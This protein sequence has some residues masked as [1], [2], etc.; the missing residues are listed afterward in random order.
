MKSRISIAI[1][2]TGF[3]GIAAQLLLLREL[4][5]V[6]AG[7]EFS[8]GIVL[9]NWL[10]LEAFG[11][12]FLGKKAED[13]K[14]KITAFAVLTLFFALSL[15]AMVFLT[16]ILRNILDI[17]I[18]EGVG[19]LPVL[20]SS[21]LVLLPVSFLHGALFTFGC[22]VYS[23]YS[24]NDAKTIGRAYIYET[25]G[26]MLGGL[27]WTYLLIPYFH[28]FETA[29]ALVVLN[30][31]VCCYLLAGKTHSGLIFL[32]NK[33]R[34]IKSV[35]AILSLLLLIF[36]GYYLISGR[37]DEL[38]EKSIE[39]QW[40]GQNI[41]HYQNSIYG[42]ITIMEVEGQYTFFLDG[43]PHI[44]TPI[45]D[46][47]F[48]EEFVH[49][50]LLSHPNPEKILILSG[51]A[52]GIINEILKHPTVADID[53]TELDPLLMELLRKYPTRLI[54]NE[55]TDERVNVIHKDGR[56]FLK[57]SEE[58]YDVV[59]V[60]LDEPSDLQTNR[61]FTAEFFKQVK[62]KLHQPGIIALHLPGS[63]SYLND[64]LK[65]LNSCAYHTMKHVFPNVRVIPGDGTNIFLASNSQKLSLADMQSFIEGFQQRELQAEQMMPWHI[66]YKLNP[67]WI[68]WF[69]DFIED[70]ADKINRDFNPIA[71]YYS[72]S[73]WNALFNPTLNDFFRWFEIVKLQHILI[74]FAIFVFIIILFKMKRSISV[75]SAT[76]YCIGTTGFAGMIFDLVLIFAFQVIYGY[77]FAWIGLLVTFFMAG[78]AVGAFLMTVNLPRLK[79]HLHLFIKLEVMIVIFTLLLPLLFIM[80]QPF[81]DSPAVL[82]ALKLIFIPLSFLSGFSV[83]I[84][85][86]LANKIYLDSES[87]LSKTAGLFYGSDLMGGWLGG[88]LGS[89]FLLP[90]LGLLETCIIVVLLKMSSLLVFVLAT[91]K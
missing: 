11:C 5:I 81:L 80:L 22:K 36:G 69:E 47:M 32:W 87:N 53:Y 85:F 30:L 27:S 59:F 3:S 67:G 72:I 73:H 42:N 51:G 40:K 21:F 12:Y 41:V 7:N 38:H 79:N 89:V 13:I 4:L 68:G 16:R 91:K 34:I 55:I 33:S 29:L 19:I 39:L 66:E 45:P 44:T 25:I 49:L 43:M 60:G 84:Q 82:S 20:Y 24:D 64:E 54:E 28:V 37:V 83:G 46:I 65:D 58:K 70:A 86:P 90:V 9:A 57:M 18:G 63:L 48:V 52:G 71:L 10:V 88:I 76:V 62:E 75:R 17:S 23:D 35:T 8:I 56:L 14:D 77:V 78:S 50:S 1:T 31:L 61:F 15:P 2:I 6:F 74:L 26:T